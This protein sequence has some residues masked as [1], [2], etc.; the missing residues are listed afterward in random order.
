MGVVAAI[1][2]W[3]LAFSL[4]K[5][6]ARQLS[7]C[8]FILFN[9]SIFVRTTVH[10]V[11]TW[12][13]H[14]GI[15]STDWA[16][17]EVMPT[18]SLVVGCAPS[19]DALEA[20]CMVT[21]F[22]DSKLF[23]IGKNHLEAHLAFFIILLDISCLLSTGRKVTRVIPNPSV[24]IITPITV[25]AE[26]CCEEL[27]HNLFFVAVQEV[28]NQC[29]FV[30][31]HRLEDFRW[32]I[33]ESTAARANGPNNVPRLIMLVHY[34]FVALVTEFFFIVVFKDVRAVFI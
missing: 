28:L 25:F 14:I 12:D 19:S 24:K 22:Q 21:S 23:S 29:I 1:L 20:E 32:H 11:V 26:T 31:L 30:F 16:C 18:C 13:D 33:L 34:D 4:F 6:L 17:S 8:L 5:V 7:Q 27:A 3:T 2:E 15:A 9:Q 10:H